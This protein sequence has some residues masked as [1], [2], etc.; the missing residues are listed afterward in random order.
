VCL[1]SIADRCHVPL[2]TIALRWVLEQPGVRIL[3]LSVCSCVC[4]SVSLYAA[5]SVCDCA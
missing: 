2:A 4:L 3:C 1:R 5:M